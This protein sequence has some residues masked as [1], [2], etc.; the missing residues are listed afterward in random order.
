M[1]GEK[2]G[3]H[4]RVPYSTVLRQT[5]PEKMDEVENMVRAFAAKVMVEGDVLTNKSVALAANGVVNRMQSKIETGATKE[6]IDKEI[7]NSLY[8]T[9]DTRLKMKREGFEDRPE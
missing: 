3:Q 5:N 6:E 2:F 9:V 8:D 7:E 1:E 4:E